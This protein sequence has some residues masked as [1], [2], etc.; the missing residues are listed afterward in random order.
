MECEYIFN[1]TI[2][3]KWNVT[4][5]H[6]KIYTGNNSVSCSPV[7]NYDIILHAGDNYKSK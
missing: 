7:L 2:Q 6:Q 1:E 4:I 3:M 5:E